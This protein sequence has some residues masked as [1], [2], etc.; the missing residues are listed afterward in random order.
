M[1]G[2]YSLLQKSGDALAIIIV[3]LGIYLVAVREEMHRLLTSWFFQYTGKISYSLY[4]IHWPIGMKCMDIS[5][6]FLGHKIDNMGAAALLAAAS[7]ILT[8]LAAHCFYYLIE[9]PS[10]K[11]SQKLKVKVTER[12]SSL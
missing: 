8:F 2:G 5:L 10:L 12:S 6:R 11:L 3:S 9:Y 1:I 4:L 7:L